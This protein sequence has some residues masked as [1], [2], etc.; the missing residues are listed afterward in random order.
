MCFKA[1][2]SVPTKGTGKRQV[3]AYLIASCAAE[4]GSGRQQTFL[5]EAAAACSSNTDQS[6]LA[7]QPV[8]QSAGLLLLHLGCVGLA[9][10]HTAA[11]HPV[12]SFCQDPFAAAMYLMFVRR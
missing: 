7:G 1:C 11:A 4:K 8:Q 5:T 3:E 10:A 2:T 9:A 12:Q 6:L